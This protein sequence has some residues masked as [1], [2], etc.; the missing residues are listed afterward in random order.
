MSDG[1][2]IQWTDATLNVVAGCTKISEGCDR[3]YIERTP[4]FRMAGR[5]FDKPGIGGSTGVKLHSE[6]LHLPLRWR[7]PRRIFVNSLSDLFHDDVPDAYIAE[8][9]A[10]MALAPQHQFQVLTKRPARM[11]SLL[12]SDAFRKSVQRAALV[13]AGD[14]APWLVEP[15]WPLRHVWI[16]VSVENQRWADIRIP[17]LMETP[18]VVRWLSCE[19]L[20][21]PVDLTKWLGPVEWPPC[22]DQHSPSAE[23]PRCIQP[24]WIVAGG[25]SGPGARP[26]HPD[27]AR[28]LRDQCDRAGV[29]F[30]YKQTGEWVPVDDRGPD[31][32]RARRE[33]DWHVRHDGYAWPLAE[34]HGADDG[35]EVTIRRVGKKAAGRELDGRTHDEYPVEVGA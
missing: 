27:W 1:T 29:P 14:K 18:A 5:K 21:G 2:H 8:L 24:Q 25:E 20:L 17:L 6:R 10:V 31:G 7:K 9:F 12:S 4:P 13:R 34:P 23:C 35:T 11:R 30:F 32:W 16:G 19:P 33:S 26:M 15:W 3:C 22:W 28:S